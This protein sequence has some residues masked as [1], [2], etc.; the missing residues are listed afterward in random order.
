MGFRAF[1]FTTTL[2]ALADSKLPLCRRFR[3]KD[4]G[5]GFRAEGLRF[6]AKGL[7]FRVVEV[8]PIIASS[9]KL[10]LYELRA[11]GCGVSGVAAL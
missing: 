4:N 2:T 11:F 10:P 6:R 3:V 7:G 5:L 1:R 9:L 8:F